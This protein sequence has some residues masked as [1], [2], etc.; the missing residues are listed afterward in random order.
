MPTYIN[1]EQF[2]IVS[3]ELKTI[4]PKAFNFLINFAKD[5]DL[6]VLEACDIQ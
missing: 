3:E 6:P 5:N 2:V 4:E 1:G